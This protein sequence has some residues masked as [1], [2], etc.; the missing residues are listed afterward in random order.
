VS[1]ITPPVTASEPVLLRQHGGLADAELRRLGL[2]PERVLDFSSSTNPYGPNP[3]LLRALAGA[4]ISRY[5]DS[6]ALLAREALAATIEVEAE[7]IVLGNGA[8]DLLWTLARCLLRPGQRALMAAPT[9]A[10]FP[11]AARCQG[12]QV[13]E[14]YA[15]PEAGFALDLEALSERARETA[16]RVLYL[17]SPNTPTGGVVPAEWI[18]RWAEQ[19]PELWVVLDQ[20]FLSLSE[21]WAEASLRQPANVAIV[22]SLT[23]DH[24][25]PGVR[26][27]YVLASAELCRTLEASRPAWSTS[28]FAQVAAIAAAHSGEF[29]VESRAR[30]LEDRRALVRAL[31]AMGVE[32]LPTRATFLV[33]RV[34][35]VAGLR[36]RLLERHAILVRD[37][38]SFG[39][40]G[41]MRLAA[42]PEH[43]RK[44]LLSALEAERRATSTRG[45]RLS[46]SGEPG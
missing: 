8:A 26:V 2:A 41:F 44:R 7:R 1:T 3:E 4:A 18:A 45:A 22:R 40:P 39:L 34:P 31:A 15:R 6:T 19:H 11:A 38:A 33:A 46:D 14:L 12:A 30:L 27:G 24:G 36:S 16:A 23:K 43:E 17:C 10:E 21:C 9:F 5:P 35:D 29:V 25:I 28:A 13:D 32:T 37:C 42:R 20:S